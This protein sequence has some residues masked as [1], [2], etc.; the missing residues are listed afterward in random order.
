[1]IDETIFDIFQKKKS[2]SMCAHL[3]IE[4]SVVRSLSVNTN[5]AKFGND[6]YRKNVND[7][8]HI[9]DFEA[10]PNRFVFEKRQTKNDNAK[11]FFFFKPTNKKLS[12]PMS[13]FH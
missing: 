9:I 7:F 12:P 5:D 8:E 3:S 11:P 10:T 4:S 2:N 6:F 13:Q 1:M